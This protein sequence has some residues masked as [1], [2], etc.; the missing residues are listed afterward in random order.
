MSALLELANEARGGRAR[1]R[2]VEEQRLAMSAQRTAPDGAF[3]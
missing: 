1:G 3:E 2:Q